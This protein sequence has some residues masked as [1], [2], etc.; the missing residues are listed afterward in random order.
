MHCYEGKLGVVKKGSKK[1]TR[2]H[3]YNGNLASKRH[4][5]LRRETRSWWRLQKWQECCDYLGNDVKN[6]LPDGF[7]R[8][9]RPLMAGDL[10]SQS[11]SSI[12]VTYRHWH[13]LV[14]TSPLSTKTYYSA[15]HW[16]LTGISVVYTGRIVVVVGLFLKASNN[17]FLCISVFS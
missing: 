10:C 2:F 15:K 13:T 1:E 17:G 6:C 7:T 16:D 11:Q 12:C 5:L 14:K 9:Q 3:Y 8:K 4:A